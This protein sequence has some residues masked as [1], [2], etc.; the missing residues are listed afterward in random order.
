MRIRIRLIAG[1]AV[2]APVLFVG[3]Q[4]SDPAGAQAPSST[5][6]VTPPGNTVTYDLS[7]TPKGGAGFKVPDNVT[8]LTL[9]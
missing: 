6:C 4:L 7:N 1:I 9:D 2:L 3:L 5:Q 8:Q